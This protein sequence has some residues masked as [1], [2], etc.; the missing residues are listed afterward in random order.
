MK[1]SE[2]SFEKTLHFFAPLRLSGEDFTAE[3]QRRNAVPGTKSF[4]L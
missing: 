3:T 2:L 1:S 4:F